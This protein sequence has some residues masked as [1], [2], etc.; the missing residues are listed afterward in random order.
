MRVDVKKATE[1]KTLTGAKTS[2]GAPIGY[3][4]APLKA[5]AALV[6][7]ELSRPTPYAMTVSS[8]G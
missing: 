4:N 8:S 6:P 2:H 3:D 7:Q 5:R 1:C